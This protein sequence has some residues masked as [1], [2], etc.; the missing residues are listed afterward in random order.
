M[1]RV[2]RQEIKVVAVR[3]SSSSF[4]LQRDHFRENSFGCNSKES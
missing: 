4:D 1:M 2:T 3:F